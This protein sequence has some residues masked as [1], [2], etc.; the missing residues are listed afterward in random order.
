MVV[1]ALK[2]DYLGFS[3]GGGNNDNTNKTVSAVN[4]IDYN[5]AGSSNVGVVHTIQTLANVHTMP[6][7]ST[8][9]S[10][11]RNYREGKLA[12]ERYFNQKGE[13]YLD[14]DYTDHGNKKMHPFVPHEHKIVYEDGNLR[15]E[16]SDG[17]IKK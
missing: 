10:V 7:T 15:R 13:P 8:P 5:T 17:R 12:T 1:I 6:T 2:G 3:S 14:I 16:K 4:G 9:N 11:S